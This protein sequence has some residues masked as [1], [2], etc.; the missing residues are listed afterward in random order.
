MDFSTVTTLKHHTII[1]LHS[2]H[3]IRI[4][5][6]VVVPGQTLMNR[7]TPFN[8]HRRRRDTGRH[9]HATLAP[10]SR[11]G[12]TGRHWQKREFNFAGMSWGIRLEHQG[13]AWRKEDKEGYYVMLRTTLFQTR[14]TFFS[15]SRL[16]MNK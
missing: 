3:F 6:D 7:S 14:F 1:N 4:A 2:P 11:T 8:Q 5:L 13:H 12:R 10:N 9:G 15:L 16:R